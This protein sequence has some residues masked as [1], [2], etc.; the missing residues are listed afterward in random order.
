MEPPHARPGPTTGEP[1]LI[2]VDHGSRRRES[3]DAL[4]ELVELIRGDQPGRIVEPAHMD[5]AEPS[6]A[7]AFTRCVA[8]GAGRI[9]IAPFFLLPGRHWDDDIPALAAAAA[10]AHPGVAY[11][12]AAPLGLHP[13]MRTILRDRETHCARVAEGTAAACEVCGDPSRCA[14]RR[15]DP[16]S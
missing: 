7:T 11:L 12:V 9:V 15:A 14:W 8:R 16:A 1:A 6:L 10:E 5:L 13:A 4:L 2:V 3:N